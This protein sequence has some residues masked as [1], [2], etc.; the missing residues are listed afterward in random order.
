MTT[1]VTRA[2]KGSALTHNEVDANFTNL[3]TTADAALVAA[4]NLSDVANAATARTNLGLAI[5]TNVQAYDADLTTWAGI[6]P[7]ANVQSLAAAADYAAMRAL[8]DLEAGTDFYSKATID[9]YL[10]QQ[11]IYVPAAAMGAATTN[12]AAT[13]NVAIATSLI[14]AQTLNFDHTTEEFAYFSV[15]MPK[16]WNAGTLVAQ[17][18]WSHTG[19]STNFGVAWGIEAVCLANDEAMQGVAWGTEVV[20]TDTGGTDDDLYI[21]GESSAITVGSTPTAEDLVYFRV[22]R[23]VGDAGDTMTTADARLHGVKI[24]YTVSAW[25]DS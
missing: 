25:S 14:Q 7:S 1:I 17:F 23:V 9:G 11:T 21:T 20:T 16:S 15:Q 13:G 19:A 22:T 6:T 5:G 18:I 8:L 2:G 3:Q 4:S 10:G 24:H 12:G